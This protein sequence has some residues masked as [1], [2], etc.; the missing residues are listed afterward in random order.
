METFEVGLNEFLLSGHRECGG[1]NRKGPHKLIGLNAWLEGVG[2]LGGVALE[3][4]CH[5]GWALGF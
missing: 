4:V 1:L 2:I 3:E 5:W